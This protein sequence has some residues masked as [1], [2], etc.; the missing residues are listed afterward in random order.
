MLMRPIFGNPLTEAIQQVFK[1][2]SEPNTFVPCSA[3][4]DGVSS[5]QKVGHDSGAR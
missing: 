5:G 3:G 1:L 2:T 4:P